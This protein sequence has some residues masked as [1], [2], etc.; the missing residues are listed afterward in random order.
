MSKVGFRERAASVWRRLRGGELTPW[1]AAASVAIGLAIGVTPLWGVHFLLVLAVCVPLSL[2]APIAYL[3]ANVSMPV[4]A[5][6]LTMAELEIGAFI[7]T[8]HSLP[9]T[10]AT[11]R[12]HGGGLF[13]REIAVGTAVFSPSIAVLGGTLTFFGT[14]IASDARA[15]R[16]PLAWARRL[17]LKQALDRVARRYASGTSRAAHHYVRS[18]LAADPVA[19]RLVALA[20]DG[21]FGEVLDA[22]CGRGQLG[23]LLL[24]HELATHVTGFD[25]DPNK[26]E[27]AT[28]A[29]RGLNASFRVGELT[30]PIQERPDTALLVD[31]LHYLSAEEQQ[32]TL[33]R[34]AR[35]TRTM[36]VVRELDPDRGWRSR[37]TRVQEAV[38]T[39]L[40]YNR[41]RH[42]DPQPISALTGVLE[43]EGFEVEVSPCWGAT[44][45]SN[46]LL[47]ARRREL[48]TSEP[49]E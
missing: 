30:L 2:D 5:P 38:T 42:V 35:S 43:A 12:E 36:V 7:L 41:G 14:R 29:A 24:E 45:F 10:L 20:P 17:E 49:S 1:R 31:V 15:R 3:A 9:T 11:L 27:L 13:M 47:V 19:E 8:G 22:G 23:V 40:R 32:A 39:R 16:D 21:G 33:H 46:V 6:F 48:R 28:L 18:K 25:W 34:V 26:V 37:M 44:P 4:V